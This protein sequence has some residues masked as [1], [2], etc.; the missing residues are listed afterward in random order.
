M[1]YT[2]YLAREQSRGRCGLCEV[3]EDH[4]IR[5]HEHG[6]VTPALSPYGEMHILI[7]PWRHVESFLDLGDRERGEILR[8]VHWSIERLYAV[9]AC[10][11]VQLMRDSRSFADGHHSASTSG[12]TRKHCHI[13]VIGDVQIMP[14]ITQK[15][16]DHRRI[17]TDDE[18]V[19][20]VGI[21]RE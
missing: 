4:I 18:M 8:L 19:S 14:K 17:L 12:K 3:N 20:R 11:V 1:K 21:L 6:Y 7:C 15:A 5:S 10:E 13:H 16:S 2:D 9:W